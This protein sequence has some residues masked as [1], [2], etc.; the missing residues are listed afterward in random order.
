MHS[1]T[2]FT[3]EQHAG[4]YEKWPLW[5]RLLLDGERTGVS[6]PGYAL[7]HQFEIPDG[8]VFATDCD[9]PFEEVTCFSFVSKQL[10]LLSRR[11]LG[12]MYESFLL[13]RIEWIDERHFHCGHLSRAPL[14]V[15]DPGPGN[16][17]HLA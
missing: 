3:L 1:I 5:S 12:C 6:L 7:L 2:R 13:E 17:L 4:P 9:C 15:H 11:W 8:F 14:P 16:P 10:R